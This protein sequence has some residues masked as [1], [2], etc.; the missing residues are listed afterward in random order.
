MLHELLLMHACITGIGC[1]Q[2]FEAYKFYNK[3]L[4]A[5]INRA[6]FLADHYT[7]GFAKTFIMPGVALAMGGSAIVNVI[8][9]VSY[10]Y[11]KDTQ[12][13]L[14]TKSF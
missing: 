7:P 12:E 10:R 6:E 3:D 13:I 2:T 4:A 14:L 11:S 1:N 5:S 9:P 8:G